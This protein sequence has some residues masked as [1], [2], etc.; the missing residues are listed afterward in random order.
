MWPSGFKKEIASMS[1][2]RRRSFAAF[3]F[4]LAVLSHPPSMRGQALTFTTFAG[5][6]G[7][8]G[9]EDGTGNAARFNESRG[10]AT[11]SGGNIYVAD[12]NN[13]TIRKIIPAGA[14]TTLAGLAEASGSA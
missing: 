13:Q 12:T 7:G 2:F 6:Q 8:A 10:V 5:T 14:V 11:D 4:G 3:L 1:L 9:F